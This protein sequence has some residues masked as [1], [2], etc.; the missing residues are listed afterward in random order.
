MPAWQVLAPEQ[1]TAAPPLGGAHRPRLLLHCKGHSQM[2]KQSLNALPAGVRGCQVAPPICLGRSVVWTR[3]TW[4]P[5]VIA[6]P[7]ERCPWPCRDLQPLQPTA[8]HGADPSQGHAPAPTPPPLTSSHRHT[9]IPAE[10]RPGPQ[11]EEPAGPKIV[12][13]SS[14]PGGLIGGSPVAWKMG[15]TTWR[16]LSVTLRSPHC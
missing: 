14:L 13:R 12:Q 7:P 2:S 1:R 9:G 10:A 16:G 4:R 5:P 8:V 15:N 3:H 11:K 6:W